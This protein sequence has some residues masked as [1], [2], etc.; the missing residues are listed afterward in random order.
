LRKIAL[1]IAAGL[2]AI[3]EQGIVHRDLKPENVLITDDHQIRCG[4]RR[5]GVQ[6]WG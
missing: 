2:V 5:N 1:Q 6:R 4:P 3:H